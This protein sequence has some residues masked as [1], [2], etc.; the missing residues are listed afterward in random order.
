M[1]IE[2][3]SGFAEFLVEFEFLRQR[4]GLTH[5]ICHNLGQPPGAL[6]A[7]TT[8]TTTNSTT[9]TITSTTTTTTTSTFTTTTSTTTST[10]TT[11]TNIPYW[12]Y[13]DDL[14]M[15]YLTSS[16]R[17]HYCNTNTFILTTVL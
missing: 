7:D 6:V 14:L 11:N 17:Y 15:S 1:V 10:T 8:T 9:T 16:V 5:V 13:N 2:S 4:K 3:V 12:L